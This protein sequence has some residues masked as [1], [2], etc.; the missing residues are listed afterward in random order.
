LDETGGRISPPEPRRDK[1]TSTPITRPPRAP[2]RLA[3]VRFVAPSAACRQER[4]ARLLFSYPPLLRARAARTAQDSRPPSGRPDYPGS[5]SSSALLWTRCRRRTASSRRPL[6]CLEGHASCSWARW[7][8]P[9]GLPTLSRRTT[10]LFWSAARRIL[11][12][13]GPTPPP[14]RPDASA[15]RTRGGTSTPPTSDRR[16]RAL[17]PV[18]HLLIE[19]TSTGT[20]LTETRLSFGHRPLGPQPAGLRRRSPHRLASSR[21]V[22]A[23][24]SSS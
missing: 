12:A 21:P 19:H 10:R 23:N 5:P 17:G 11:T 6:P 22:M 14:G 13:P 3:T 1:P 4:L 20:T 15:Y 18:Q 7:T 2:R 8:R 16:D 24:G 9:V